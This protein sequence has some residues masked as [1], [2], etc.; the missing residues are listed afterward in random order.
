M[1]INVKFPILEEKELCEID[2]QAGSKPLFLEVTDKNGLKLKKFYVQSGNSP[3]ELAI[4]EVAYY[5]KH[6]FD[7]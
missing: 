3:Q 1:G 6:R 7:N 4:D 5:S 2:I